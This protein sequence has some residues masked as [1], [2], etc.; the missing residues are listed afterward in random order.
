M[1][2]LAILLPSPVGFHL[3]VRWR[4][5]RVR[6]CS[7][8]VDASDLRE[9]LGALDAPLLVGLVGTRHAELV[10]GAVL[11]VADLVAIPEAWLRQVPRGDLHRRAE[12][13]AR[14]LAAHRADPLRHFHGREA[15]GPSALPF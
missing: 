5:D 2:T 15:A 4:R 1:T 13:A 3:F 10:A 9:V 8:L 6:R 12:V 11:D 14:V 7:M